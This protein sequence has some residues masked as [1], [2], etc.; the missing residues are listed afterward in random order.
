[1][2][3]FSI[4]ALLLLVGCGTGKEVINQ[5]LLEFNDVIE[6]Q[7]RSKS[8][9]YIQANTWFV[10]SFESSESVIEFSD[11]EAGRI[12]GKY[13]FTYGKSFIR[14]I[15]QVD[16]KDGACRVTFKSPLI[17]NE[18]RDV[19]YREPRTNKS[20]ELI[21]DKWKELAN[22]LAEYLSSASNW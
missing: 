21:N 22:D 6:I 4:I 20:L 3:K 15:I 7:G 18:S 9:L 8:D 16:V 17:R 10:E 2:N 12:I 5:S 1:M 13:V 19:D 11:K 14:S